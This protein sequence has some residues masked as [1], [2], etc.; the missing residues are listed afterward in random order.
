LP[1]TSILKRVDSI[2]PCFNEPF[3]ALLR[4]DKL[5]RIVKIPIDSVTCNALALKY[6]VIFGVLGVK[7]GIDN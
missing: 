3:V 1:A 7:I 6:L 4:N 5:A 2:T